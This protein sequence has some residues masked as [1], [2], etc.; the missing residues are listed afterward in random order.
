MARSGLACSGPMKPLELAISLSY[1]NVPYSHDF[2]G[3]VPR[4][5]FTVASSF[6]S[7]SKAVLRPLIFLRGC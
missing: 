4:P 5:L 7:V 6:L 3:S 1:R 2:G